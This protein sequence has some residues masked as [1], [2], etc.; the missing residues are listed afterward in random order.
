MFIPKPPEPCLNHRC[1]SPTACCGWGY[2]RERNKDF[3]NGPSLSAIQRMREE[4]EERFSMEV[5]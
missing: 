4:A 1:Y 3:P 2:C 5:L